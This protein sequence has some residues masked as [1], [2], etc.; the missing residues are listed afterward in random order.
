MLAMDV[1]DYAENLTP[2]D[3][4]ESIANRFAPTEKRVVPN[5]CFLMRP[6]HA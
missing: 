5:C 2:R 4:L 1:N 3:A 6:S